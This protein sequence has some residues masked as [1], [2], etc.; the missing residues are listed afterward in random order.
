VEKLGAQLSHELVIE[1]GGKRQ[2]V[3][4]YRLESTT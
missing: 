1:A 4:H 3:L 2:V